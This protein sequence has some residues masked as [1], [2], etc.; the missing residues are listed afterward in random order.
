[1]PLVE[2]DKVYKILQK[3]KLTKEDERELIS[4]LSKRPSDELVK[5]LGSRYKLH[6]NNYVKW[7]WDFDQGVKKLM[8]NEFLK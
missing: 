5:L 3:E 7:D 4:I 6:M 2:K 1:M 8:V